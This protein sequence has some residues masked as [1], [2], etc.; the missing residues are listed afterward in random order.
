VVLFILW[1]GQYGYCSDKNVFNENNKIVKNLKSYM[2]SKIIKQNKMV[3][4][5]SNDILKNM[6]TIHEKIN[7]PPNNNKKIKKLKYLIKNGYYDNQLFYII[8]NAL[9]YLSL[10]DLMKLDRNEKFHIDSLTQQK[11]AMQLKRDIFIFKNKVS[12]DLEK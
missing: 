6:E 12:K 5:I 3:K 1:S 11:I 8:A 4:S 10:D 2:I 9:S 7:S